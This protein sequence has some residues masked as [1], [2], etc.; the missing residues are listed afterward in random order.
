MLR[1]ATWWRSTTPHTNPCQRT[2]ACVLAFW[3]ANC[4]ALAGGSLQSQ[5]AIARKAPKKAGVIDAAFVH[6]IN[7]IAGDQLELNE[8]DIEAVVGEALTKAGEENSQE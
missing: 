8:A 6:A 1:C 4:C 2:C 3:Y 7:A 5:I